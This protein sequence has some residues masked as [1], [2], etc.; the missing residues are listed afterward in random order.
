MQLN[1]GMACRNRSTTRSLV[2]EREQ[3]KESQ[4]LVLVWRRF[5]TCSHA[6]FQIVAAKSSYAV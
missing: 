4:V 5:G 3:K 1:A 2:R 6:A